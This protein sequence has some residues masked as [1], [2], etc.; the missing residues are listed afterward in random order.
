M[1]TDGRSR[2]SRMKGNIEAIKEHLKINSVPFLDVM[3]ENEN[4]FNIRIENGSLDWWRHKI[5]DR[6]LTSPLWILSGS[7]GIIKVRLW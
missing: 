2:Y 1:E 5:V 6:E 7:E 3:L 4:T